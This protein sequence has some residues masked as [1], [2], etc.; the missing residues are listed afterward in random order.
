MT[1]NRRRARRRQFAHKALV[2]SLDGAPLA[3]CHL[4]DVSDGG[5]RLAMAPPDLAKLPGEFVLVLTAGA[6][7]RR[8]CRVVW[9]SQNEAG[10]RF[11]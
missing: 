7:V 6:K 1:T 3:D 10:I 2:C 8:G 4:R 9:R 5:A 11:Q